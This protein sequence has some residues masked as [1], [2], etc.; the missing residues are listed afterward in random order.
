VST[1]CVL[2]PRHPGRYEYFVYSFLFRRVLVPLR[3]DSFLFMHF[4]MDNRYTFDSLTK[5]NTF[6]VIIIKFDLHVLRDSRAWY[7]WNFWPIL[8]KFQMAISPRGVVRSTSCLV[9]RWGFLGRRIEWRYFR[10]RQIQDGGAAAILENSNGDI[11]AEDRPIYFVFGSRMGFSGSS[12]RMALFPVSPN[13]R[14]RLGRHLGKFKWRYLI[15]GSS[16]LLRVWFQDGVF[17]VGG[18][19]GAISGFAKSK[20]SARPPSWKIQMAISQRRIVRF[21]QCLVIGRVFKWR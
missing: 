16:D 3:C 10:F 1:C 12:D 8:G 13:P 14:C 17:A 2:R 21:T 19:N 18:S 11:S 9:L 15:G 5:I 7:F 6:K 20:M 4:N